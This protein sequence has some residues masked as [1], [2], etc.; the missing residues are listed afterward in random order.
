MK[1][2]LINIQILIVIAIGI[3]S[4]SLMNIYWLL[5]EITLWL[6]IHI[7]LLRKEWK[8][9]YQLIKS[10]FMVYVI[11]LYIIAIIAWFNQS[12]LLITLIRILN[13]GVITMFLLI[14]TVTDSFLI[15]TRKLPI[16]SHFFEA[17]VLIRN[18]IS[19]L[20]DDLMLGILTAQKYKNNNIFNKGKFM[21]LASFTLIART[22][23]IITNLL[24]ST[25]ISKFEVSSLKEITHFTFAYHFSIAL[26]FIFFVIQLIFYYGY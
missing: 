15:T 18:F 21:V 26:C 25:K 10:V 20:V 2:L 13:I 24:V 3:Y 5:G 22:P 8:Y 16:V 1:Y 14:P 11:I 17:F 9:F 19:S 23:D 6:I 12:Q 4:T 7:F